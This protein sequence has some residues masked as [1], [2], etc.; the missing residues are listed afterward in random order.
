MQNCCNAAFEQSDKRRTELRSE[1]SQE[2]PSG[3]C[4]APSP[5]CRRLCY[6]HGELSRLPHSPGDV[7]NPQVVIG[8]CPSEKERILCSGLKGMVAGV[9]IGIRGLTFKLQVDEV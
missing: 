3:R 7:A 2:V 8:K 9:I 6:S 4:L 1:S 5:R